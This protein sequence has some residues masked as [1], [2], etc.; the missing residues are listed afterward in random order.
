MVARKKRET[1]LKLKIIKSFLKYC[2]LFEFFI[3]NNKV[4]FCDALAG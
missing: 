4:V 2:H 3:L 1:T